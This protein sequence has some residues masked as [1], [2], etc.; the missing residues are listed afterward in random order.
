MRGGFWSSGTAPGIACIVVAM[1]ML[2]LQ[3][4]LVKWL[5]PAYALHQ[6]VLSRS[7]IALAL[8]LIVLSRPPGSA[9]SGPAAGPCT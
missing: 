7:V 8:T 1:M 6:I 3:D 5:S 9:T 4:S 2:S